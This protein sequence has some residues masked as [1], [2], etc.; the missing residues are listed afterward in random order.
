MLVLSRY[1]GQQI[2]I[3]QGDR[4]VTVTVTRID[5]DRVGIGVTCDR[6]VP[7]HRAEVAAAIAAGRKA[8]AGTEAGRQQAP[9][10]L[11]GCRRHQ[12]A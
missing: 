5:G 9:K 2:V 11:D 6:S 10:S 12:G 4:E 8:G 7:V 3:G 1:R